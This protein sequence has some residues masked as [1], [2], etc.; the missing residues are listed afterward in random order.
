MKGGTAAAWMEDTI[1]HAHKPDPTS[2]LGHLNSYGTWEQF[3]THFEEAFNPINSAGTALHKLHALKQGSDLS[4]YIATFKQLCNQAEIYSF[5]AQKDYFL[6]GLKPTLLLKLC[7]SGD[8]P[9]EMEGMYRKVI[10]IENAYQ[11]LLAHR[12]PISDS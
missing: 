3:I 8:I 9:I 1:A 7:N 11:L 12:T 6:C 5:N 4:E 10:S 2:S